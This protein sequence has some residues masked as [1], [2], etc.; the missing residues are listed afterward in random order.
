MEVIV[1]LL[2]WVVTSSIL[3][4]IICSIES[5]CFESQSDTS[6]VNVLIAGLIWPITWFILLIA[7][8]I[9]VLKH[10]MKRKVV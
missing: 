5:D 4:A 8:I 1:Y 10:I 7:S 9:I 2:M 6:I 3:G